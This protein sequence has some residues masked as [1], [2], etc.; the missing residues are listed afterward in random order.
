VAARVG[1]PEIRAHSL[2]AM[3]A[4]LEALGDAD[5]AGGR[6]E[7]AAV[8]ARGAGLAGLHGELLVRACALKL[9]AG[10]DVSAAKIADVL[11]ALGKER[12]SIPIAQVGLAA[13]AVVSA[14]TYADHALLPALERARA[15]LPAGAVIERVLVEE[16]R[17]SL[18]AA[19]DDVE[20]AALARDDAAHLAEQ[21]GWLSAARLLRSA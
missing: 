7:E 13:L 17:A 16:M 18:L 12:R 3:G 15:A 2:A 4:L 5:T 1:H 21:T 9:R 19:L 20:A 11:V 14:R 6:F 8:L 10:H